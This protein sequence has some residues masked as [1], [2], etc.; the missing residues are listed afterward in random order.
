MLNKTVQIDG[1]TVAVDVE[2]TRTGYKVKLTSHDKKL[3]TGLGIA[4]HVIEAIL[5]HVSGHRAGVAGTYNRSTYAL[6]KLRALQQWAE[7]FLA[8][9][10]DR[11][12]I[13]L[14]LKRA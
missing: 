10:E 12:T 6:E 7:H 5:N 8:I 14:P 11:D 13:V 2:Q 1:H 9:V 3:A 4:P